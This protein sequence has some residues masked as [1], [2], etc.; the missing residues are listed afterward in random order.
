MRP[1]IFTGFFAITDKSAYVN[2]SMVRYKKNPRNGKFDEDSGQ[3]LKPIII[4][5][6]RSKITA[7]QNEVFLTSHQRLAN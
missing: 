1:S 5:I 6:L 3:F 2:L 7:D 4:I